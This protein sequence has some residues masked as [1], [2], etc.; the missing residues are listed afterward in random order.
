M[1]HNIVDLFFLDFETIVILR[2]KIY[3][4]VDKVE[5]WKIMMLYIFLVKPDKRFWSIPLYMMFV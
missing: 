3:V 2:I 5:I 1:C 4:I